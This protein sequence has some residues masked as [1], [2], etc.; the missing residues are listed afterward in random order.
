MTKQGAFNFQRNNFVCQHDKRFKLCCHNADL[1]LD[2]LSVQTAITAAFQFRTLSLDT[3]HLMC[4]R[5]YRRI[6]VDKTAAK[7]IV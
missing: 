5:P 7:L 4:D 2:F 1:H 3:V 6:H